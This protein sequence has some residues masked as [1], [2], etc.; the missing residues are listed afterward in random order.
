MLD[1]HD[2]ETARTKIEKEI[3]RL[4]TAKWLWEN[5]SEQNP[6]G[7][8]RVWQHL[9]A[10]RNHSHTGEPTFFNNAVSRFLNALAAGTLEAPHINKDRKYQPP[11]FYGDGSLIPT[12]YFESAIR[13]IKATRAMVR[14][15][16]VDVLLLD[17][18]AV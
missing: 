10:V 4:P 13:F 3:S 5:Q 8:L 11:A 17:N 9:P 12:E 14:W 15:S 6:L 18:H 1:T 2:T 16:R 7:D